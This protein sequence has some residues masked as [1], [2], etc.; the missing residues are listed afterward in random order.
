MTPNLDSH[1][2]IGA[3]VDELAR[4]GVTDACTS[5]G[6]RCAPLVLAL[7]REGG[8]R[9][10]SHVDERSSGFFAL[11]LAKT[12]GRPV[13][14]TC[15]S[16]TA[17]ANLFPA[18][19]EAHE[20]RVP[21]IV[22]TAD[23]PP[24][25]RE[26]GAGQTID[27]IK[28]YGDAV[29]WFFEVGN[30]D[31]TPER[32][33]WMRTLACRAVAEATGER[34]GP[35]HLNWGLREPLVPGGL[36]EV[37]AGR[38]G[39]RP[40]VVRDRPVALAVDL[41]AVVGEALRG[42]VVAGRSDAPL[43]AV[44]ALAEACGYPLI[45]DPLSGARSGVAAVAHYD[46][47][48][49]DAAFVASHEPDVVIRLG[50]LPTSK[51]L[52]SWLS[53]L[54]GARQIAVDPQGAWQDPAGILE[55]SLRADP[56][57]LSPPPAAPSAWLE[58]W[59]AEDARAAAAVGGLLAAEPL[60]E[61]AVARLLGER[62][63]ADSLLFVASSMPV[64]EIETLWPVREDPPR[65]LSNRGANGIDGTLSSA[66]GA[67]AGSDGPVCAL[68]GDVAFA[69]DV[70]GL[71]CASRLGL[72]VT[73]VLLDNGGGAIFDH[74]PIAGETDV[75]EQHIATPPGVDF[76]AVA[77]AYALDYLAPATRGELIAALESALAQPVRST[78]VHLRFEREASLALQRRLR[79]ETT[80]A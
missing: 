27:Q 50:D 16:G 2:L 61:L 58:G 70:G 26:V 12:S 14:V 51:V 17:A 18:V 33:R 10:H 20:A 13:A 55:R 66:F 67:R 53:S 62:L 47:L 43:R 3:F 31:A 1:V 75:Y 64:R 78:L 73:F 54:A 49:A 22:L 38:S 29:R 56:A 42:V 74:L 7:A 19:I 8:L 9:A 5:P 21:L 46:L 65:V 69:H 63:P 52:R 59:R 79:A 40:W 6:S 11:G 39:G 23:R 48:L 44:P 32:L 34:P 60:N 57:L 77:Q 25:L 35:V 28:L 15:T 45:A 37:P 24:E 68:V 41:A 72:A 36:V 80:F 4:C 76:E 30:H 71:L